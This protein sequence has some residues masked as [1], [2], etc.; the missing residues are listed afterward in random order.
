VAYD[1]DDLLRLVREERRRSIGFGDTDN[2]QLTARRER[3]LQYYKG[4]MPDVPALANRSQV[5]DSSI[6]DAVE[7]VLPDLMDIFIGGDDVATFVPQGAQDEDQAREESD[8]VQHVVLVENDGFLNFYTT[9]KD[10]LLTTTGVF[11]WYWEEEEHDVPV[12]Q[13]PAE[14]AELAQTQLEAQTGQETEAEEQPDGSVILTA[15]VTSGTVCIRAVPPEDFTVAFDT[16]DL[17]DT[18]YCAMRER[19]RVQDLILRGIDPEKARALPTYVIRN[20]V[21]TEERDEAGENN[22]RSDAGPGDLRIVEARAH[23]IRVL[24]DEN[25]KPTIKRVLTDGQETVTLEVEDVDQIP[26]AGLTPYMVPHRFYGESVADKLFEIQRIKTALWRAHLDSIYFGLN[27]R[28]EVAESKVSQN[29]IADLLRNEPGVPVRSTTG[30]AV[31]PITAGA[32]NFDTL[33]SLEFAATVAESRS[34]IVRNAQGLN[35]DTLHDTASGALALISAAQKRV[36]MI[37]RVLAETGIKDLFL[38]VH[39][40][41]R[42]GYGTEGK[43]YKPPSAKV[44]GQWKQPKPQSWPKR[45]AMA[46]QVGVGGAGREHDLAVANNRLEIMERLIQMQGGTQ[47]P[48]VDASNVHNALESWER[49]SATKAPELYWSDPANTPPQQPKPDPKMVE[50]QQNAQLAQ[51]QAQ[52]Q[53]QLEQAK[54]AAK[55]KA[56]QQA[57]QQQFALDQQRIGGEIELKRQQAQESMALERWKAEQQLQLQREEAAATV[58]LKREELKMKATTSTDV[59]DAVEALPG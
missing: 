1:D 40:M 52:A 7:T 33:A 51:Q 8:Y 47:G 44:R 36:R 12:A 15:K 58:A 50:A 31:R 18:T 2:G 20:D 6:A 10:A 45:E 30:D 19:V 37:A 14:Q 9:I 26:F 25:G 54:A 11:Y 57:A 46:I 38:G 4:E 16:V 59:D 24:D 55:L 35:P 22:L 49:A 48:L 53:L 34:G 21:I 28:M 41:L 56:D 27:Q 43:T 39:A 23:F 13:V 32:P 3:A 17:K 42:Q 29:T 5:V